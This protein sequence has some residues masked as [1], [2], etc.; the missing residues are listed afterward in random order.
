MISIFMFYIMILF[1]VPSVEAAFYSGIKTSNVSS[2]QN[3]IAQELSVELFD[4]LAFLKNSTSKKQEWLTLA[5][6]YITLERGG[7][8]SRYYMYWNE[9]SQLKEHAFWLENSDTIPQEYLIS[10]LK[11]KISQYPFSFF[12]QVND[13][14]FDDIVPKFDCIKKVIV[15]YKNKYKG[16]T[17]QGTLE[18]LPIRVLS[19]FCCQSVDNYCITQIQVLANCGCFVIVVL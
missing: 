16:L 2:L 18:G 13:Y 4:T 5:L 1:F 8:A 17:L 12:D 3:D 19:I 6:T 9:H 15:P 14:F 10:I 11:E 7:D